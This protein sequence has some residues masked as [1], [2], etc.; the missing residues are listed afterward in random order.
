VF[1]YSLIIF[2]AAKSSYGASSYGGNLP[3]SLPEGTGRSLSKSVNGGIAKGW[4]VR[5]GLNGRT[6]LTEVELERVCLNL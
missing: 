4:R 3:S 6:Q 2:A 5:H 1:L